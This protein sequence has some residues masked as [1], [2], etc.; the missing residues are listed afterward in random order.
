METTNNIVFFNNW[1][2]EDFVAKWD[3]REYFFPA[4]KQTP[5]YISDYES[6]INIREKFAYH[7]AIRELDKEGV[8]PSNDGAPILSEYKQRAI[9]EVKTETV[10]KIVN[11]SKA[12]KEVDDTFEEA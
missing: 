8:T 4:N 11:K 10:E 5:I 2:D 7:L 9:G 6:N 12:K 1:S 3:N